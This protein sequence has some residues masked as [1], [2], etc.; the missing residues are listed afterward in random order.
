M[1]SFFTGTALGNEASVVSLDPHSPIGFRL[2]LR[3][4]LLHVAVQ[5]S[6]QHLLERLFFPLLNDLGTLVENQLTIN[7]K[8]YFWTLSSIPLELPWWLRQ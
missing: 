7:I 4:I 3:F 1:N 2:G 8:F 5:L 6:Q